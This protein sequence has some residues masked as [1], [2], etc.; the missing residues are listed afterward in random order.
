LK[1]LR[2]N[3]L[4]KA[5]SLFIFVADATVLGERNVAFCKCSKV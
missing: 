1:M 4:S 2:L 3:L 5:Y